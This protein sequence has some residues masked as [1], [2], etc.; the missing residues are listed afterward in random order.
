MSRDFC[1]NSAQENSLPA[2]DA[3]AL[4]EQV[5]EIAVREDSNWTSFPR[6]TNIGTIQVL[7]T[8]LR[9]EKNLRAFCTKVLAKQDSTPNVM[10]RTRTLEQIDKNMASKPLSND[11]VQLLQQ[12][13]DM[14]DCEESIPLHYWRMVYNLLTEPFPAMELVPNAGFGITSE[15]I[16]EIAA[17][18]LCLPNMVQWTFQFNGEEGLVPVS[19]GMCRSRSASV[20][21]VAAKK[22]YVVDFIDSLEVE[23]IVQRSKLIDLSLRQHVSSH[24]L[25]GEDLEEVVDCMKHYVG[26]QVLAW[27]F[28]TQANEFLCQLPPSCMLCGI[29]PCPLSLVGEYFESQTLSVALKT[30]ER[31]D[32]KKRWSWLDRIR[33][34]ARIARCVMQFHTKGIA[35]LTLTSKNVLVSSQMGVRL[36]LG[37]SR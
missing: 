37:P 36:K 14:R 6:E 8:Q 35:H 17:N 29:C 32:S 26:D 30:Q 18:A 5:S 33:M 1:A 27:V 11:M 12:L 34:I 3:G 22:L 10:N 2:S 31:L 15:R 4:V 23:M 13:L 16:H 19:Q 28:H 21:M 24:L 9:T 25:K 7:Q 20:L